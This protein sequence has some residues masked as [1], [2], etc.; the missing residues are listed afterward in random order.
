MTDSATF[1]NME[2]NGKSDAILVYKEMVASWKEILIANTTR[3]V[4]NRTK[5]HCHV[6]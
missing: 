1:K 5:Y 3:Y 2:K 6:S 4:L